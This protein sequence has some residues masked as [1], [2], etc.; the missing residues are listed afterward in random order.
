MLQAPRMLPVVLLL[1][2]QELLSMPLPRAR[3]LA[4]Q[5]LPQAVQVLA[6]ALQVLLWALLRAAAAVA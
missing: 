2:L 3:P 6:A 1:A 4:L 5:A